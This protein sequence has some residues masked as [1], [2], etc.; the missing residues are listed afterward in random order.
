MNK[1]EKL[2]KLILEYYL[3]RGYKIGI[4]NWSFKVEINSRYKNKHIAIRFYE[5]NKETLKYIQADDNV[6]DMFNEAI[7]FFKDNIKRIT[8]SNTKTN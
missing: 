1:L 5:N 8:K 6:K 2:E 7:K 4:G 3:L